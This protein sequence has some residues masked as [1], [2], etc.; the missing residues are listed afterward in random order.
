MTAR[1]PTGGALH[2]PRVTSAIRE[3]ALEELA[4]NGYAR[5]SMDAV[6]RRAG[7]GKAAIY[8]R[9]SSKVALVGDLI[10]DVFVPPDATVTGN[11][12]DDLHSLMTSFAALL[13]APR[14]PAIMA[15]LASEA[16][17]SPE[18]SQRIAE[19]VGDPYRSRITD[20]LDRAIAG[21]ELP[22]S[23]D[24]EAALDLTLSSLYWR[25]VVRRQSLEPR[26]LRLFAA[27]VAA[28]LAALDSA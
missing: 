15:D 21:G 20:V 9:W 23:L 6:A 2:R 22:P 16:R 28:G 12:G 13:S 5:L 24:R 8:R 7:V 4:A 17:R 25:V 14:I 19:T 11:L 26:D 3:A 1:P 18:L 10:G 27:A